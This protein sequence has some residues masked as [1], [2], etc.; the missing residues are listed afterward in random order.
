MSG[1]PKHFSKL[2]CETNLQ[3]R[4]KESCLYL[5]G[6]LLFKTLLKTLKFQEK[7]LLLQIKSMSLF[8][9]SAC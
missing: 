9:P 2:S 3:T 5:S 8:C 4:T 7:S 1:I 6:Q